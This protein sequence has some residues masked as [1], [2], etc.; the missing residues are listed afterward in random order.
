M[1]RIARGLYAKRN[2]GGGKRAR[3]RE[4]ECVCVRQNVGERVSSV[5]RKIIIFTRT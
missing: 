3:D 4:R 1:K 2:G 5:G